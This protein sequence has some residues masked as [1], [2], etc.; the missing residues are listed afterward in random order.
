MKYINGLW[1][2][3]LVLLSFAVN[4]QCL[5]GDCENGFG[6]FKCDCGYIFEGEFRNGEKFKGT[7][8]KED[9]VYIGEF[10]ND[11]AEG[12]GTMKYKDGSWYEGT[13][14]GNVPHGYGTYSFGNGQMYIGE[15]FEG[16]FKGLGVQISKDAEGRVEEIRLGYY[17]DDQLNGMGATVIYGGD[18]YVGEFSK[19]DYWGFGACLFGDGKNPD[20][21]KF[22]KNKLLENVIMLDYPKEGIFGVKE[23]ALGDY[24]YTLRGNKTDQKILIHVNNK[25]KEQMLI[26]FDP[27][28]ELFYISGWD[29]EQKG[30]II[31]YQGEIYA[32]TFDI[33]QEQLTKGDLIHKQGE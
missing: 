7:L 20:A 3:L 17:E 27:K 23:Y 22:R 21:G 32:G 30:K 11:I 18:I 29:A 25:H 31:N 26:Y 5:E 15:I 28:A 33:A 16:A 12:F 1:S 14:V 19:G 9:L 13:F 8:T 4:A 24:Q 10:K 6:K 2:V